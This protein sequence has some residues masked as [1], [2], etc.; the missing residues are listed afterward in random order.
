MLFF[1]GAVKERENYNA[2]CVLDQQIDDFK[3]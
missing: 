1:G 2:E 3:K